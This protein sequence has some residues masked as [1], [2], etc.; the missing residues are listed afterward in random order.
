MDYDKDR[1]GP[2]VS[3]DEV[4]RMWADF[5]RNE[6][7]PMKAPTREHEIIAPSWS[8]VA[9]IPSNDWDDEEEEDEE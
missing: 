9:E 3:P 1:F 7:L 4:A 8:P 2:G 6:L 5:G